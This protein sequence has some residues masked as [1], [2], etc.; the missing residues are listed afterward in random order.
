MQCYNRIE[1]IMRL[2]PSIY[3]PWADIAERYPQITVVISDLDEGVDGHWFGNTLHL[4]AQASDAQ[5]RAALAHEIACLDNGDIDD[6][7]AVAARALI[8]IEHLSEAL[9]EVIAA[10]L[11][12]IADRLDVDALTARVRLK[13]LNPDEVGAVA[14]AAFGRST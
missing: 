4:N 11:G 8:P 3:D 6:S 10:S 9:R 1:T 14:S 7:E 5:R 13:G 2:V 12:Q